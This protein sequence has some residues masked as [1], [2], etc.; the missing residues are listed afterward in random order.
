MTVVILHVSYHMPKESSLDRAPHTGP[1]D[2]RDAPAKAGTKRKRVSHAS[3]VAKHAADAQRFAETLTIR[4][5]LIPSA[6]GG[7]FAGMDV[8]RG[9][10][11]G[12][13]EGQRHPE[14]VKIQPGFNRDYLMEGEPGG[15]NA[16][17]PDGRLRLKDGSVVDIHEWTVEDWQQCQGGTAWLGVHANWTRFINHATDPHKNLSL[18]G[19]GIKRFGRSH[20]L[21]A[22][23][24]IQAGEEVF[25]S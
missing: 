20:A 23:R 15:R 4:K 1:L 12:F 11:V 7:V 25:Y 14:S 18:A 21:Y 16:H 8:P 17:D 3:R 10:C 19:D 2:M 5:S 24:P 6:G 22:C 13:Y 9:M